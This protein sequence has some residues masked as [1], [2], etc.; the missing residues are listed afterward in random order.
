MWR[1]RG[2]EGIVVHIEAHAPVRDVEQWMK[3]QRDLAC[4]R[5]AVRINLRRSTTK[6]VYP[7]MY[8]IKHTGSGCGYL[9]GGWTPICSRPICAMLLHIRNTVKN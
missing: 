8:S 1:E 3:A 7:T 6:L 9:G 5:R 4:A 2:I